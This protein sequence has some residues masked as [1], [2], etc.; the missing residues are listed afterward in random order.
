LW[1]LALLCGLRRG[2]LL[3]LWWEDVDLERGTLAI[4]R[5]L[6][7]SKSG[8]QI[9]PPKTKGSR[10][11]IALPSSCVA[12]LRA[13]RDRQAFERQRLGDLWHDSPYIFTNRTGG[14]LHINTLIDR[15]QRVTEAAGVSTIR[16]HDMRHTYATLSLAAGFHPKIVSEV[17][18][19]TSI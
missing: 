15:F 1:R 16:F 18:G 9:G 4:R 7:K 8:W 14:P 5:T 17:L 6:Q 13:H 12:A 2:E 11:S 10:R 19:H 3:A